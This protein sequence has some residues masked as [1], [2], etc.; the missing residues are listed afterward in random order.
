MLSADQPDFLTATKFVNA[1]I[2][3]G[4]V[5]HRARTAFTAGGRSY[6][7]GSYVVKTA[8]AFRAHFGVPPSIRQ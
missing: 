4:I 8:Q 1:L 3:A 5:V 6:P 7:E 2:K